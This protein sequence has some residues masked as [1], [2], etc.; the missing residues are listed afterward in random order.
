MT[1]VRLAKAVSCVS[2]CLLSSAVTYSSA[3]AA[4]HNS[5]PLPFP[6]PLV[7]TTTDG[8]A[9]SILGVPYLSGYSTESPEDIALDF[10]ATHH[11]RFGLNGRQL[12]DVVVSKVYP[13]ANSGAS[14]VTLGQVIAG[15]RV[16]GSGITVAIDA[17]GHVVSALGSLSRGVAAGAAN[18]GATQAL[19]RAAEGAGLWLDMSGL[20]EQAQ[21]GQQQRFDNSFATVVN[22]NPVTA[23]LVWYPAENGARLQLAWETDFEV[24]NTLWLLSYVDASTG[25]VLHQENRYVHAAQGTVFAGQHPEDSGPRAVT[26]F[27]GIDGTW[28]DDRVTTGNNVMAYRDLDDADTLGYQP[29]TDPSPDPDY[30]HFDYPWTNAWANN[31]DGSDTSLNADLDAVITQ[32]FYYT[33]VMHDWLYSYGFDEASGNFQEDNFGRGGAGGDSVLAEAQDGWNFGCTNNVGD[34]VRCRNNANFGTPAD[35]GNPRMQMYM[36][37]P[38]RPYRDGSMDGDVIAHE[39]GHGVSSRLVGGGNLGYG[40][41]LVHASLGEGWSDIISYLKWGDATVGEYVTGNA[42]TGIRSVAYDTSTYTYNQYNPNAGS[43]HPNGEVWASMVYDIREEFGIDMTTQLVIDGMKA[44]PALPDFLDA[45]DGIIAADG[46]LNGG[47]NFCTLWRIFADRG[48]G[49]NATFDKTSTSRPTDNFDI[50]AVCQPTA[51]ANGPYTTPE[52][53]DVVLDASGSVAAS[54]PSG[55]ALTYEW[56]LDNDGQYDDATGVTTIFNQVGDNAVFTVG[57]RVTNAAGVSDEDSTS[58]TVTNAAPS[59]TLSPVAGTSENTSITVNGTVS[60]PGWLDSLTA[61][62]DWGDGNGPQPLTGTTENLRPDATL[63]FSIDHTYGDN[64]DYTV[65]VCGTDD[66]GGVGCNTIGATIT[67]TDPTAEIDQDVYLAHVGETLDVSGAS[68]DPG[69]DD[70]TADWDWGDTLT[71]QDISLVNPPDPDPAMSPTIQPRDVLWDASHVYSDACLYTLSLAVTD[72]DGGS[73]SDTATVIITGNA[74]LARTAGYWQTQ[75]WPRPPNSFTTAQLVC[76]L[77]IVRFMSDVFDEQN[78]PLDTRQDAVRVLRVN[79]ANGDELELFDRQLL[80]AWLNFANGAYDLDTLVDTDGDGVPDTSFQAAV[81]AA[82]AVRLNP[83]STREAV[84]A[85]KD[86]LDSIVGIDEGA[87]E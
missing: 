57:L 87:A 29:E 66:D 24:D 75:Y 35:G 11:Q 28:V 7:R 70:L 8:T 1:S 76:Y 81:S 44:T 58:V 26:A 22:P 19:Q 63:S 56:D 83:A 40:T 67:N 4:G 39:Y 20:P 78:S 46:T 9:R 84:L 50:P 3:N 38:P 54:D 62:I 71:D 15:H 49:E 69:S 53:T 36:W 23:E 80:A 86:V 82:E 12:A 33:N 43:G 2:A 65:Q 85:Q 73:A 59:V 16:V 48:L 6:A 52:G 47:V 37:N 51:D 25:R 77:D 32:L 74:A 10:V 68:T 60:D 17:N 42:A 14:Y 34:P 18:L 61:T 55:G 64:G 45:R 31:A 13:N 5:T 30:Q 79:G 27:S 21:R 72:D 41:H